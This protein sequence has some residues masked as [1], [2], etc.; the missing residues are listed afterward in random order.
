MESIPESEYREDDG[1]SSDSSYEIEEENTMVSYRSFASIQ[2]ENGSLRE[3]CIKQ[4]DHIVALQEKIKL[5]EAEISKKNKTIDNSSGIPKSPQEKK[6]PDS[7]SQRELDLSR[8]VKFHATVN[9]ALQ[10]I[11]S[12]IETAAE[13]YQ[14]SKSEIETFHSGYRLQKRLWSIEKSK[15]EHSLED[16]QGKLKKSCNK[17]TS[18]DQ[19]MR[20]TE[21][22]EQFQEY[23]SQPITEANHQENTKNSDLDDDDEGSSVITQHDQT[24]SNLK[25]MIKFVQEERRI[26]DAQ[27]NIL[28]RTIERG[29]S[30]PADKQIITEKSVNMND[31]SNNDDCEAAWKEIDQQLSVLKSSN[32]FLKD[33]FLYFKTKYD[34]SRMEL[35]Q[36]KEKI[37]SLESTIQ[38]LLNDRKDWLSKKQSSCRETDSFREKA[39]TYK[40]DNDSQTIIDPKEHFELVAKVEEL[41]AKVENLKIRKMKAEQDCDRLISAVKRLNLKLMREESQYKAFSVH[42]EKLKSEK[43]AAL[44]AII[45]VKNDARRERSEMEER[46][47]SLDSKSRSTRSLGSMESTMQDIVGTLVRK[48]KTRKKK[49]TQEPATARSAETNQRR[50]S[51]RKKDR[52]QPVTFKFDQG[53]YYASV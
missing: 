6:P 39:K 28:Y 44:R 10:N 36:A 48:V 29:V 12:S 41:T 7:T 40:S 16:V 32:D 30:T 46:L 35:D 4:R 21:T 50:S 13:K 20:L 37:E 43:D 34:D 24:F 45:E 31:I 15:F 9:L 27:M 2:D 8:N 14:T 11:R 38:D 51:S 19:M 49:K 53:I 5:L 3:I 18:R 47:R 26:V 33:K 17:T 42:V 52:Q 23:I 1:E 25:E 22:V